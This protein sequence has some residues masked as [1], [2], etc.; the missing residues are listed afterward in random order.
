VAN[1]SRKSVELTPWLCLHPLN[2]SD[3]MKPRTA[4][5]MTA[6][7]VTTTK[8]G[9]REG[10]Q[11]LSKVSGVN[12]PALSASVESVRRDEAKDSRDY[13]ESHDCN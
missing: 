6:P 7:R 3:T 12:S 5:S 4:T 11:H 13:A 10:G 1:A 9:V 2:R 8:Q